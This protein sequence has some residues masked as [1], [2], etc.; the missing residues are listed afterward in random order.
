MDTEEA[1]LAIQS[2]R[3]VGMAFWDEWYPNL[4]LEGLNVMQFPRPTRRDRKDFH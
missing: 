4:V 1:F 3:M 2:W